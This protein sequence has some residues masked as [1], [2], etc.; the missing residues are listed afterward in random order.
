MLDRSPSPNPPLVRR[1]HLFSSFART[2]YDC[3]GRPLDCA[4]LSES[5]PALHLDPSTN[6]PPSFCQ[7]LALPPPPYSGSSHKPHDV[8]HDESPSSWH[9]SEVP[10][11]QTGRAAAE[12]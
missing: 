4:P 8:C 7:A 1:L 6:P 3:N 5:S 2:A 12:R 9:R 11:H 10:A